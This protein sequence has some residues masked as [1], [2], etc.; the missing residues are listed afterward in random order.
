MTKDDL[1]RKVIELQSE[2]VKARDG[3][4]GLT[5]ALARQRIDMGRLVEALAKAQKLE[6]EWRNRFYM[7][8]MKNIRRNKILSQTLDDVA[9]L[10]KEVERLKRPPLF[11]WWKGSLR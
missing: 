3:R 10:R 8:E 11:G 9:K 5:F 6:G 4:A 2:L 7:E 1:Q